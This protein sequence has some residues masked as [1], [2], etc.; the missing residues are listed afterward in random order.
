[1]TTHP[2]QTK[3]FK[4]VIAGLDNA[5]KTS[6]LIALRQKYNFY[7]RVKNLKPTIK[8]DYSS[9]KFLGTYRINLWDMGG[10]KKF[11]KIYVTNPVYFFETDY[12]YYLIDIQDEL[13]FEESVEYLHELLDIYRDLNYSNEVIICYNKFDP[14]FKNDEDYRDRA[15]MIKNLIISQNN[16]INFK[17]FN[18][19]YYDISSI[20]QALSYSL[21]TLLLLK[22]IDAV[23]NRFVSHYSCSYAILYTDSGLIISD[24]YMEAMDT[25]EFEE[26]IINKIN[27]DLEFFQRIK[28]EKVD[29]SDRTAITDAKTNYV[30]KFLVEIKSVV[31]IFY[32]GI[33]TLHLNFNA[34]KSELNDFQSVLLRNFA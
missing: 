9:F 28:D 10:Q 27:D 22:E 24:H 14:K 34:I 1:M 32:V 23:L 7:E 19:S 3:E 2:H 11:R 17:F 29:I 5:G 12:I 33:S 31:N 18:T 15:K 6:A 21:N 25:R 30:R 4:L 20:S 13:K 26:K 16:D 8:I